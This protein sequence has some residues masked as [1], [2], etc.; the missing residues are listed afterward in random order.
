[1]YL[2][3]AASKRV[4]GCAIIQAVSTAYL[5]M[6]AHDAT[7]CT[8]ESS[9]CS[10]LPPPL[11]EAQSTAAPVEEPA[12]RLEARPL[13]APH[14]GSQVPDAQCS[15]EE[16]GLSA[17]EN[18]SSD[19]GLSTSMEAEQSGQGVGIALSGSLGCTGVRRESSLGA[20]SAWSAPTTAGRTIAASRQ[21]RGGGLQLQQREPL[22]RV[23]ESAA[24]EA[25]CGVRVIWVSV[26]ARLQGI[27]T[28]LLDTAR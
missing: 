26:E 22:L 16:A 8:A 7:T 11:P 9:A 4:V 14:D 20:A 12:R 2:Y 18:R 21:G 23:D 15:T 28:K 19:G 17:R 13:K 25:A 6:P 3:V 1:M 27:A 5:A 24:V 10:E